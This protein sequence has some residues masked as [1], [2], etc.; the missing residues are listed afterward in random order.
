MEECKYKWLKCWSEKRVNSI[1]RSTPLGA[2]AYY[3]KEK[4]S[5]MN[6]LL[7]QF[8]PLFFSFVWWLFCGTDWRL[9]LV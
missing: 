7:S 2:V 8:L 3:Y 6:V 9:C 5:T 1:V 4:E